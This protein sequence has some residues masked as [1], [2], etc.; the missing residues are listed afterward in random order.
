MGWGLRMPCVLALS[1]TARRPSGVFG[2]NLA[3]MSGTHSGTKFGREGRFVASFLTRGEDERRARGDNEEQGAPSKARRAY[4]R[5]GADRTPV[6][7]ARAARLRAHP[8]AG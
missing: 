6:R 1:L 7:L 8:P 4:R 5:L 3:V 2:R